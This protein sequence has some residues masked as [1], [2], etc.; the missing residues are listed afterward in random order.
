MILG[1]PVYF[2]VM[3]FFIFSIAGWIYESIFVSVRSRKLVNRGFLIGPLLP[4][5]GFGAVSVYLLLRP[6]SNV[7][8][9]L[10]VMGMLVATVLEYITSVLLEKLF[11]TRWWDYSDEAYNFQGR[12]ALVPS[13]FWGFLSLLMFDVLQPAASFLIYSIPESIGHILL[14]VGVVLFFMDVLYSV[15]VAIN[16]RKQLENLYEFRK[17]IEY[18]LQDARFSSV[19]ELLTINAKG[20]SGRAILDAY[21]ERKELFFE[22]V[23]GLREELEE[24]DPRIVEIEERLK[25]YWEKRTHFLKRNFLFGNQRL[26][27]AF[28]NMK[29]ISEKYSAIDV[30]ELLTNVKQRTKKIRFFRKNFKYSK[31]LKSAKLFKFYYSDKKSDIGSEK[32]S[33]IEK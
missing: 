31:K 30:K 9:L 18:L 33:N 27:D 3:D 8:S 5:Y 16:L 10:Y 14:K 20:R 26:F 28:P 32:D 15:I 12:I 17:E 2:V 1:L 11:H 21:N 13:M 4:L 6:F 19:W 24:K 25:K 23:K 29:L 22:R 7:P